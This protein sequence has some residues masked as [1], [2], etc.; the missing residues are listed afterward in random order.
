VTWTDEGNTSCTTPIFVADAVSVVV[1]TSI[2]DAV[3]AV[4]CLGSVAVVTFVIAVTL[5]DRAVVM[6]PPAIALAPS[7]AIEAS[8]LDAVLTVTGPSAGTPVTDRVTGSC[9]RITC[10][11]SVY[12]VAVTV[13][14]I[15]L[16]NGGVH[17]TVNA[18]TCSRPIAGLTGAETWPAVEAAV[19]ICPFIVAYAVSLIVV[20]CVRYADIAVRCE[21]AV[22][23]AAFRIAVALVVLAGTSGP[24]CVTYA[25]SVCVRGGVC[26]ALNAFV[27]PRARTAFAFGVAARAVGLGLAVVA[28]PVRKTPTNVVVCPDRVANTL[29]TLRLIWSSTFQ[30][31]IRAH[32]LIV[33]NT[34]IIPFPVF[35]TDTLPELVPMRII[36]AALA[37]SWIRSGTSRTD[38]V[39]R[40][41][42]GCVLVVDV[43]ITVVSGPLVITAAR[44]V[45]VKVRV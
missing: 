18:V 44:F 40:S 30:A 33:P 6:R 45:V 20:V 36:H 34:T 31:L 43:V 12:V 16:I 3:M 29:H 27:W 9:V 19:I 11:S 37:L 41:A 38:W 7:V 5:P 32:A 4:A 24:E 22:A 1:E 21:R 10:N 26:R 28:S 8:M 39:A 23:V 17:D 14:D 13:A 25:V 42:V 35:L 2:G 15:F